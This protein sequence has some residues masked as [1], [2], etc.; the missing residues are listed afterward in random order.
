[1]A[2]PLASYI[3]LASLGGVLAVVAWNMAE[4]EEFASLLKSSRGDAAILVATFLLTIFVDLTVA[5]GVGVTLGA[6]LVLHRLAEDVEIASGGQLV[7]D[8]AADGVGA[9]RT[10]YDPTEYGRDVIVYRISGAFFFAAAASVRGNLDRIGERPK[11]FVLDFADVPRSTARRR[12]PRRLRPK[13]G[14]LGRPGLLHVHTRQRAPHVAPG[15]PAPTARRLRADH[16]RRRRGPSVGL[17]TNSAR[18]RHAPGIVAAEAPGVPFRI[19]HR[20]AATAITLAA[21]RDHDL[22]ALGG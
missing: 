7:A 16:R 4:K 22:S 20:I 3:P 19:A 2:A 15:R 13:A 6:F 10:S 9:D 18:P 12:I 14:A 21:R 17:S 5:I 1:M 11:A 8:D